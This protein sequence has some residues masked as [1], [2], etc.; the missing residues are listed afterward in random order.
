MAKRGGTEGA[1]GLAGRIP[2]G[3]ERHRLPLGIRGWRQWGV[4]ATGAVRAEGPLEPASGAVSAVGAEATLAP[5]VEG[6]RAA[7]AAAVAWTRVA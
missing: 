4:E 6:A 5:V 1:V 3:P 7:G 2:S